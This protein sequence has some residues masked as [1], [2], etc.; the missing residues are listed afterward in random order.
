MLPD[1]AIRPLLV[2]DCLARVLDA[3]LRELPARV[4]TSVGVLDSFAVSST[5]TR[6]PRA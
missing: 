5:G 2:P 1:A 4:F 3:D 6:R